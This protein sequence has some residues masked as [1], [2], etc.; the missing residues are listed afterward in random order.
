MPLGKAVASDLEADK[1]CRFRGGFPAFSQLNHNLRRVSLRTVPGFANRRENTR[2][3]FL[4]EAGGS[5]KTAYLDGGGA[6]RVLAS[7]HGGD[8]LEYSALLSRENRAASARAKQRRER[9]ADRLK[10]NAAGLL[11]ENQ[12]EYPADLLGVP[13]VFRERAENPLHFR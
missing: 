7:K 11:F 2:T 5:S 3:L 8:T 6:F 4:G 10:R 9:P 13:A 1:F 12:P